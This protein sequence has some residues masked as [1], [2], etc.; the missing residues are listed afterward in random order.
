M[1]YSNATVPRIT[2]MFYFKIGWYAQYMW[3]VPLQA[4]NNLKVQQADMMEVDGGYL[5]LDAHEGNK[6]LQM[7]SV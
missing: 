4:D 7:Q 6:H 1:K 2:K 3:A 5:N